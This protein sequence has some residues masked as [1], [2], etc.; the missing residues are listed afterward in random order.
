MAA[1]GT[2][3]LRIFLTGLMLALLTA[4]CGGENTSN[5]R[6]TG[7]AT[8]TSAATAATTPVASGAAFV[9][10]SPPLQNT[11]GSMLT[12]LAGYH[13]YY[14]PSLEMLNHFVDL[15]W[16]GY[17]AFTAQNLDVG[18]WYFSIRAYNADGVESV[19]SETA[20]KTII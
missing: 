17:V 9:T 4:S 20:S 1:A 12:D 14:G 5:P 11:D 6:T 18:T 15:P 16:G 3:P 8:T 2:T 10:W 19:F 7:S 13:I